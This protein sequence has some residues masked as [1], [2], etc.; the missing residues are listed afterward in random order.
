MRH[1][2][3]LDVGQEGVQRD[4]DRPLSKEG[5]QKTIEVARGLKAIGLQPSKVFF[6]PL[7]RAQ[8]T[9]QIVTEILTPTPALEE[10]ELLQPG[11][12]PD[13]LAAWLRNHAAEAIM[14][15]G[16]LPDIADFTSF[17]ISSRTDLDLQFKKASV[18]CVVFEGSLAPSRGRLEW[19]MQPAQLRCLR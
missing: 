12:P 3:A 18:A 14:T 8:A 1:G 13:S 7:V 4:F 2:I 19:L 17:L 16:H 15:V 6:S 5:C 11:S 9:A 10:C